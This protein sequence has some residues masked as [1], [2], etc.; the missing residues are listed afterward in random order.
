MLRW[1]ADRGADRGDHAAFGHEPTEGGAVRGQMR[2]ALRGRWRLGRPAGRAGSE[3]SR[4]RRGVAGS[5][6]VPQAT[7][8]GLRAGSVDHSTAGGA[9]AGRYREAR[10]PRACRRWRRAGRR[11]SCRRGRKRW[12]TSWS[13]ATRGSAR[14][15]RRCCMSTY[16]KVKLRREGRKAAT[17][18]HLLRR[19]AG[20]RRWALRCPPGRRRRAIPPP[21]DA[22]TSTSTAH[23]RAGGPQS[24]PHGRADGAAVRGRRTWQCTTLR[25]FGIRRP[26]EL[27]R[28]LNSL[29]SLCAEGRGLESGRTASA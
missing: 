14:R 23:W 20:S 6:G 9:H 27:G 3:R 8:A 5:A 15:W 12:C 4:R 25:S 18:L 10:H 7:G 19:E 13:G 22:T 28:A 2:L 24:G 26:G 1:Y 16:R 11:R 21:W 17:H 29:L